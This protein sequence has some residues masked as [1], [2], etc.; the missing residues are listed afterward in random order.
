M[1]IVAFVNENGYKQLIEAG[2]DKEIVLVV[3]PHNRSKKY[4]T[5]KR[6]CKHPLI[7]HV[8]KSNNEFKGFVEEIKKIKP[9]LILS[10]S[11]SCLIPPE[12]FSIAPYAINIHGAKLPLYQGCGT[13][14]W[15]FLN[16]E[17]NCGVTSHIIN[18]GFDTGDII[19]IEPFSLDEN[20]T[21]IE[22][23]EKRHHAIVGC[24]KKTLQFVR[25]DKI[26]KIKRVQ[27]QNESL[28]WKPYTKED[29]VIYS[30]M[31]MT[32]VESLV[33]AF[34]PSNDILEYPNGTKINTQKALNDINEFYSSIG[35]NE[36]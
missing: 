24:I 17:K 11:Y 21:A 12:V 2:L 8:K 13:E 7:Q 25:E 36:N 5:L 10:N 19:Y 34:Y 1:K 15:T 22:Y 4:E 3:G 30:K 35:E 23:K 9:D 26:T 32:Y 31:P 14:I 27:S 18:E 6:I 20:D 16:M 33:K 29:L 28:Y